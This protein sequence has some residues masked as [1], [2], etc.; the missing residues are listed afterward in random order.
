MIEIVVS[1]VEGSA[2]NWSVEFRG[3]VVVKSSKTPLL[4][5]ARML[6]A[7][8]PETAEMEIGMRHRGA[9]HIALHSMVGFAAGQTVVDAS[10][11]RPIFAKWRPYVGAAA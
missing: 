1:P 3:N 6:L 8:F 5:F 2:G 4:T 7:D 11:G 9:D 10:G